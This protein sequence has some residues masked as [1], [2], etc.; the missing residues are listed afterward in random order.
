MRIQAL[1]PIAKE[2][3]HQQRRGARTRKARYDNKNYIHKMLLRVL[4]LNAADLN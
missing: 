1:S 4:D 2:K 3:H